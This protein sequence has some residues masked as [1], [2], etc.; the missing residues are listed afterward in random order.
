[1]YVCVCV[2]VCARAS[3]CAGEVGQRQEANQNKCTE[4]VWQQ[5]SAVPGLLPVAHVVNNGPGLESAVIAR[6]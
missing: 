4:L 5:H 6:D 3:V 1:M 2:C